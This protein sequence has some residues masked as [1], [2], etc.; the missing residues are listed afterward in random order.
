MPTLVINYW[1][2]LVAAIVSMV[3]GAI[4]YSV[5]FGKKWM[6]LMDIGP[7]RMEELKQKARWSYVWNFLALLVMAFVLAHIVDY[8][9]ATTWTAG[10]Q[11]GFWLWLGFIAT[12]SLG[13]VLWEGKSWSLYFINA[14]YHLVELLVM[15]G[16]LAVWG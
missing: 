7:K 6:E 2:I 13:A 15:G 4:W 10:M 3:I 11:A 8:T 1:A 9:G 16:I 5:L 12:V 14:G